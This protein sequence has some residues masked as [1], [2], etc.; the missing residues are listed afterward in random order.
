[1]V[2][3]RWELTTE[4]PY[5]DSGVPRPGPRHHHVHI[6]AVLAQRRIRVPHRGAG[7]VAEHCVQDLH[8]AVRQS[9][10]V[11]H[12]RPAFDRPRVAKPQRACNMKS[13]N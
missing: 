5:H 6:Q 10:R 13:A 8:A 7:E 11:H 4:Y 12:A 2:S 9:G 3:H 1:M